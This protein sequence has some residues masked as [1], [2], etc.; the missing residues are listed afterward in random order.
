VTVRKWTDQDVKEKMKVTDEDFSFCRQEC[1][2]KLKALFEGAG[3]RNEKRSKRFFPFSH[4]QSNQIKRTVRGNAS[5]Q[6]RDGLKS[7][8]CEEGGK[9]VEG[10]VRTL[11]RE[12]NG[13]CLFAAC[14]DFSSPTFVVTSF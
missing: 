13:V 12:L 4:M 7:R 2:C 6:Q 9:R 11:L 3:K 10:K 1:P 5:R 14:M 8:D